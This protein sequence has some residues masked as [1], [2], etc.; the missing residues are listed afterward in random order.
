ML[1]LSVVERMLSDAGVEFIAEKDGSA[2][3]RLRRATP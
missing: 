3:V 2:G 1:D